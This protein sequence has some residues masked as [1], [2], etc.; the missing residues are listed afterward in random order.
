MDKWMTEEWCSVLCTHSPIAHLLLISSAL[1]S[2][3]PIHKH[4]SYDVTM[5]SS[6]LNNNIGGWQAWAL[7][8][9]AP[10]AVERLHQSRQY[11][12]CVFQPTREGQAGGLRYAWASCGDSSTPQGSP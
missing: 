3:L 9:Q 2:V 11:T 12:A 5:A 7:K 6:G 10:A 1:A 8:A 4:L